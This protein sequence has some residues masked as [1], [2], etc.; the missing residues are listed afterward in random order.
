MAC[1]TIVLLHGLGNFARRIMV[2]GALETGWKVD[3][4]LRED[5]TQ[6]LIIGGGGGKSHIFLAYDGITADT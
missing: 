5:R 6:I 3:G 1:C 4:F 2:F